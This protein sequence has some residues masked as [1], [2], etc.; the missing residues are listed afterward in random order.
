MRLC[1]HERRNSGL[2]LHC[3]A[4]RVDRQVSES[5]SFNASFPHVWGINWLVPVPLRSS[6]S[7]IEAKACM[8]D[9]GDVTER[10]LWQ[11]VA[12]RQVDGLVVYKARTELLESELTV[13]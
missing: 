12:V 5:L 3:S 13:I 10:V 9:A 8:G 4:A 11:H 1:P 2:L 6:A 7:L